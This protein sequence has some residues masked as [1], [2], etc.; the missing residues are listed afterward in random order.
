MCLYSSQLLPPERNQ[1]NGGNFHWTETYEHDDLL[2]IDRH[3]ADGTAPLMNRD[4][5]WR[6]ELLR[7]QNEYMRFNVYRIYTATWNVNERPSPADIDLHEWLSTSEEPPDIYAVGFQELAMDM[8]SIAISETKRDA[9]MDGWMWVYTVLPCME[10]FRFNI[11]P[12]FPAT[13]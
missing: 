3:I 13:R 10:S 11:R 9:V 7:R 2:E 5:K 1:S 4:S 6:E 8:R 12:A